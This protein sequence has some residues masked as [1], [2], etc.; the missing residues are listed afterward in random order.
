MKIQARQLNESIICRLPN[1][2]EIEVTMFIVVGEEC[3]PDV[4]INRAI[5]LIQSCPQILS[6]FT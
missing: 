5:R 3:D 2:I 6:K 1:G 4:D